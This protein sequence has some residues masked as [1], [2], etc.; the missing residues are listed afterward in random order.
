MDIDTDSI[1]IDTSNNTTI[2]HHDLSND[3]QILFFYIIMIFT[4]M[5]LGCICSYVIFLRHICILRKKFIESRAITHS[6]KSVA[7]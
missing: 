6:I 5:V 3:L 7:V 4:S 1:Y 2:V